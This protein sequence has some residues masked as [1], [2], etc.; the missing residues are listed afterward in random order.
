MCLKSKY[1]NTIYLTDSRL[2]NY[3]RNALRDRE[4]ERK[5]ERKRQSV[6]GKKTEVKR[7]REIMRRGTDRVRATPETWIYRET[8]LNGRER[9]RQEVR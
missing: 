2:I 9:R 7:Q 8:S 5:K 1:Y 6:L 4:L 3:I